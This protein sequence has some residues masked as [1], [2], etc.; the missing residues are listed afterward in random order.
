MTVVPSGN[1]YTA[2]ANIEGLDYRK[3][4]VFQARVTDFLGTVESGTK[5]V[6]SRPLAEW[7]ADY[8]KFNVPTYIND[9]AVVASKILFDGRTNGKIDIS[10]DISGF[11]YLEILFEDNNGVGGGY[12][13]VLPK[14]GRFSL[15][16][17]EPSAYGRTYIRR[18]S[19]QL[20]GTTITPESDPAGG[21]VRLDSDGKI[22]VNTAQNYV[23]ITRVVGIT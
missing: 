23:Y 8:W 9:C 17:M 19:Y 22:S 11:R 2:T 7:G 14:S 6:V 21:Y 18:T 16:L 20:N 5:I 4:Y 10:G 1:G 15:W 12:T 13:R 3:T